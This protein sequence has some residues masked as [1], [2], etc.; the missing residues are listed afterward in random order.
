MSWEVEVID[1][2][3]YGH[4]DGMKT[5]HDVLWRR[6]G[7]RGCLAVAVSRHLDAVDRFSTNIDF[8]SSDKVKNVG[9]KLCIVGSL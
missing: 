6:I 9:M 7:I 5:S 2:K 4:D 1:E 3:S 8:R